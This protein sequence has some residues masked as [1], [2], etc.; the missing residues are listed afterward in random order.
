MHFL[1]KYYILSTSLHNFNEIDLKASVCSIARIDELFQIMEE[2]SKEADFERYDTDVTKEYWIPII[3][4]LDVIYNA[5]KSIRLVDKDTLLKIFDKDLSSKVS[6]VIIK[7]DEA[8]DVL[9]KIILDDSKGVSFSFLISALNELNQDLARFRMTRT[10]REFSIENVESFYVFLYSLRS[11]V[12]S[13][14][15]IERQILY[16]REYSQKLV[17]TLK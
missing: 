7:T 11:I 3:D 4:Q 5:I 15:K 8:F 16:P 12:E 14:A 10:T 9:Q 17:I 6:N 13:I 1:Q 2:S